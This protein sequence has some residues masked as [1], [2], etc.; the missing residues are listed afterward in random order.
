MAPSYKLKKSWFHTF[1]L[2]CFVAAIVLLVVLDYFNLESIT[3]FNNEFFFDY[4]WKGRL[5]LLFFLWLFVLETS[6]NWENQ[7]KEDTELKPLINFKTIASI[8]C[9]LF[10]LI[11]IISV[12]FLGLNQTV[13]DL[14]DALRGEYW[15]AN[16]LGDLEYLLGVAWPLLVEYIVFTVS[17]LAT[18]LLAYGKGGVKKF[19]ITLALIVGISGVY[20]MDIFF[21]YGVFKPLQLLALPTA[22]CAAIFLDLLG[23]SFS[24]SFSPGAEAMPIIRMQTGGRWFSVGIAWPCAGVHS[25]FLYTLIILL[26]FKKSN[27]SRFRKLSYFIV[28]AIGTYSV[29]I[30]RILVYFNI[31]ATEGLTAAQTFHDVYAELLFVAWVLLYILLIILIQKFRLIEKTIH[32]IQTLRD[33]LKIW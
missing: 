32:G 28:G 10:P 21:P 24:L 3:K 1:L 33:S 8:I 12:N 2:A 9:A 26:L 23:Y 13:I 20:F 4:T 27:I 17:F 29:N 22:A 25:M 5:F 15:R 16:F 19:G 14:G 18:I 7:P 30:L 11:Y 31:L 6:L